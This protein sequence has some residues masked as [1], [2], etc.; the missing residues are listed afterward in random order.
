MTLE[1]SKCNTYK[2][3]YKLQVRLQEKISNFSYK[4]VYFELV[5]LIPGARV[6]W[7]ALPLGKGW[8]FLQMSVIN[9]MIEQRL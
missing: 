8:L 3:G 2:V 5:D 4:K 1:Q 9:Q 6:A 7:P